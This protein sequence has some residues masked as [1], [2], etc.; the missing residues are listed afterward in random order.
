MSKSFDSHLAE[1]IKEF[2]AKLAAKEK[3]LEDLR[4][5]M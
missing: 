3:E 2:E 1:K 5:E 4:A